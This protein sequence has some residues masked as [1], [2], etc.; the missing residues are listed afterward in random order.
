MED[1]RSTRPRSSQLRAAIAI[2][3]GALAMLALPSLAAAKDRNHDRIPDRWEK[4]HKLSLKVKQTGRDQDRDNLRNL[5]E[6]RHGTNPRRA[7]SDRDGIEDGD[8]V[9]VGSNPSDDDSDDDG[10]EDADE[11]AGTIASFDGTTLTIDLAAGGSVSGTVTEDTRVKCHHGE[12]GEDDNQNP[13]RAKRG[14]G[15]DE[16]HSGDDGEEGHHGDDEGDDDEGDDGEEGHHGDGGDCENA[17]SV[18]DLVAGAVVHEA[19]IH[20]GGSGAVFAKIV[21]VTSDD[22]EE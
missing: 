22:S 12:S 10:V 18:D 13:T 21:L 8:E 1:N 6:F 16:G 2:A 20:V 19:T 14:D 5:G 17:C 9:E 15:G 11:N 3:L 4:R 7:D